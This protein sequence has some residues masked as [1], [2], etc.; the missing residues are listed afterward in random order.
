[1]PSPVRP[2][3]HAHSHCTPKH[4]V[5]G[6]TNKRKQTKRRGRNQT[7][8]KAARNWKMP[9][10]VVQLI[11]LA[12]QPSPP[13]GGHLAWANH[14]PSEKTRGTAGVSWRSFFSPRRGAFSLHSH[15]SAQQ[16][17][18]S[19]QRETSCT[20]PSIRPG[21]AKTQEGMPVVGVNL[22]VP[23]QSIPAQRGRT[24]YQDKHLHKRVGR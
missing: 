5:P 20:H 8:R 19:V 14:S 23:S 18:R 6:P 2:A 13:R 17:C 16:F 21:S 4:L 22:P 15:S 3:V 7:S 11:R 1:M 24:V 9:E 12:D 10:E